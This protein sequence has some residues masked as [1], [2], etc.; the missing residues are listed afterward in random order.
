M[1]QYDVQDAGE[2]VE[3]SELPVADGEGFTV[4]GTSADVE[5]KCTW[6]STRTD[7][8]STTESTID[9]R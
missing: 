5:W 8:S 6:T 2:D 3:V 1:T 4:L 7:R 9:R